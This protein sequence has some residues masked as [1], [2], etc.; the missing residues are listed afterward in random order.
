MNP[1]MVG[2]LFGLAVLGSLWLLGLWLKRRGKHTAQNESRTSAGVVMGHVYDPTHFRTLN[3][4]ISDEGQS[5]PEIVVVNQS[6]NSSLLL[7]KGQD[8]LT[9]L[10]VDPDH[11]HADTAELN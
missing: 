4:V 11:T 9:V 1:E 5:R 2:G 8:G 6:Y 3:Y 10:E 7:I